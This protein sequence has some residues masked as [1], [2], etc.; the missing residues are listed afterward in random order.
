MRAL[1]CWEGVS[2]PCGFRGPPGEPA[3]RPGLS[4][5]QKGRGLRLGIAGAAGSFSSVRFG[6]AG[7]LVGCDRRPGKASERA[8]SALLLAGG[9]Q[10][11]APGR[12]AVWLFH[13]RLGSAADGT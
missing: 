10:T 3:E 8:A 1:P 6:A 9:P 11:P 5:Q 4:P 7:V 12:L 13:S 2:S